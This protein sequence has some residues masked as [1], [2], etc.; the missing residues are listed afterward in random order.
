M[1]VRVIL[2]CLAR[3]SIYKSIRLGRCADSTVQTL[4]MSELTLL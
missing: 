2:E 1:L 4:E 3:Y